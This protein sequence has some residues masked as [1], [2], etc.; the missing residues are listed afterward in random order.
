MIYF[1]IVLSLTIFLFS[2]VNF[3]LP[4]EK[5]LLTVEQIY[6]EIHPTKILTGTMKWSPGSERISYAIEPDID[7]TRKLFI[8]NANGSGRREI[9][10]QK[11]MQVIENSGETLLLSDI[12]WLPDESA[13]VIPGEKDIWLYD[14]ETD[15][16]RNLT[17]TESDESVVQVSG[18]GE[19]LGYVR[20]NDL[21]V[22]DLSNGSELRLTTT[23]SDTL[24]NGKL[25]WVYQ[26]ELVGRGNFKGFWWSP[27]SEYLAYLQFDESP[28]PEYPMVNWMSIHPELDLIRYPKAGDPN[29]KVRL[30]VL[31]VKENAKTTWMEV[32]AEDG[33]YIPRVYWLPNSKKLIY[34][35]LDRSQ[36]NLRLLSGNIRN[37]ETEHIL[38]ETD[39]HW[40][41]IEDQVHFF[42]DSGYFI[43]GAER[44]GFRHL[45]LYNTDGDFIKALTHGDWRVEELLGVNE[46]EN[47]VYFTATEKDV[48]ERHV[49]Q[50]NLDNPEPF[51]LTSR[52]GTHH[53]NYAPDFSKYVH[54]YHDVITPRQV[55]IVEK[56][57]NILSTIESESDTF[58]NNYN[59]QEPEFFKFQD[60]SNRTF[61]AQI[62][63]PPNF[64][65]DKKYPVLVYVYGGPHAQVVKR[66]YGR[67]RD[68]WHQMLA[69]NG[70]II[71]SMDNRG[72][73]GRGHEWETPVY[74][75]LGKIELTDQLKGVDYLK[76]LPYV[77]KSRIGIWGWSYG[78]Y[79]TLYALS[80]SDEFKMGISVAPVT[81]WYLY[82][83]IYTERY[84]SLPSLNPE[85]YFESAP[86]HFTEGIQE[87]LLLVH[88]TGDDNVHLQN[89]IQMID[90]M[91]DENV[92][93]DLLMYP[94]MKHSISE[95]KDRIHLFEKMTE[96]LEENL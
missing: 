5:P 37:G 93:F 75:N 55:Q 47:L 70:Y 66:S 49:Y 24:L 9:I 95:T 52:T 35:Y 67:S 78:G 57:G 92:K 7:S 33:G 26:E 18:N 10:S 56:D 65:A 89:S 16:L 22:M 12:Q 91:I 74:E 61:Y 31:P 90:S 25:D 94:E 82:D 59:L 20:K 86:L 81:S 19:M 42:N 29:P 71:F 72:S 77:D 73:Y 62:I 40:L 54:I 79:M 96:Y 13:M 58:I 38:T 23:G 2:S 83:T 30:G 48:R 76:S 27:N 60:E 88:G 14:M 3:I 8:Q 11:E 53:F 6:T 50:I 87:P 51:R 45:Y 41:N 21:Y 84:M 39:K 85:G 4:Q 1:K 28:V 32:T 36:K 34:M 69:Q 64:D 17:Q 15:S 80:K 43:W 63:R 44:T 68:L 46:S